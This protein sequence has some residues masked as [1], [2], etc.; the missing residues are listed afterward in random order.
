MLTEAETTMNYG[1]KYS[2]VIEL[3]T[4][5]TTERSGSAVVRTTGEDLPVT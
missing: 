4:G 5:Q 2:L 1:R 3:M